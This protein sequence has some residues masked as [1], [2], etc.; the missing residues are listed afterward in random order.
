MKKWF[1]VGLLT[2][3][4]ACIAGLLCACNTGGIG[5]LG[6]EKLSAPSSIS[7]DGV[8]LTWSSVDGAQNY[9]VVIG[10][11]T[12]LTA[13][14][15]SISY[16]NPSGQSFTVT[17]TANAE[18]RESSDSVS[19]TFV[20]LAK[21]EEIDVAED[22]TLSW[23]VVDFAT[24]YTLKI[25]GVETP[26]TTVSYDGLEAGTH[27]VSVKPTAA[28]ANEGTS[29]YAQ[30]SAEK[31]I[32]ICGEVEEESIAYSAVTGRLTWDAV[33]GAS[34]YR[35]QISGVSEPV[36]EVVTST[37]Y[38]YDALNENFMA[39]VQAVGNHSS[40]F[41]AK[42]STSRSFVYLET[43]TG[44]RVEDGVLYWNEVSGAEGYR[45]MINDVLVQNTLTEC[46]YSDFAAGRSV[47]VNVMPVSGDAVYFSSWTSDFSFTILS[48]PVLQWQNYAL[49]GTANNNLYWD[50]IPNAQGYEVRLTKDG[51]V[52]D[53]ATL[54]QGV[55]QYGNA[56]LET[57]EYMVEVKALAD[58]TSSNICDSKYSAPIYIIRLPSPT[59]ADNNYITSDA[60]NVQNGFTVTFRGVTGATGYR[61]W[62]DNTEYA[63]TTSAQWHESAVIGSSVIE[64]QEINY[65][66][67]SIGQTIQ[68]VGGKRTVIL[69]SLSD[70]ALAFDITVL[71]A[72]TGV[73]ITGYEYT[74]QSVFGSFGYTVDIGGQP[75]VNDDL[76]YDLSSLTAGSHNVR[77]CAR[78]ND[79]D[80][81]SSNY[82]APIN[83]QRL[84]A[85]LDVRIETADAEEGM[86]SFTEVDYATGYTATFDGGDQAI[87]V[88]ELG[89]V[90]R[91]ISTS[92]TTV[93]LQATANYFNDLRTVYYMTSQPGETVNFIKLA[94]PTFGD[95]RFTGSQLVWNAPDNILTDEFTPTYQVY[96]AQDI[97][98]NGE[99]NGTVMS[100]DY[101]EGG[102]TYTFKVKAVGNVNRYGNTQYINS[103]LS[104]TISVYKLAAPQITR[105]ETGYSWNAVTNAISYAV[106][107]DGV[108]S[109]T[110]YH[111]SGNVYTF[112][113]N[114]TELKTYNVNVYAIGDNGATAIDSRPAELLQETKQLQTPDFE[115]SY[116]EE[117]VS[118]NGEIIV[119][120]TQE[121]PYARGYYYSV[122]GAAG[123]AA[124]TEYRYNANGAGSFAI[125][126]Y[127]LGGGFDEDGVYYLDSQSRGGNAAYTIYLLPAPNQN[128][129]NINADGY[130]TWANVSNANSY[131][132][133]LT[134]NG[135]EKEAITVTTA[136]FDINTIVSYRDVT[137]LTVSVRAKGNSN[138]VTSA[139]SSR[140]WAVIT[141]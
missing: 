134:I 7:Y 42:E 61:I 76:S 136:S 105:T 100:T 92:G 81:L 11:Q 59:F 101:L 44:L 95:T 77:V 50:S 15:N 19:H 34:A 43:A 139:Q 35:L 18:G 51:E 130:I 126:V 86:L 37:S 80:I 110:D 97:L 99:R 17:I 114:F 102:A 112:T 121:S 106:Y 127:A 67:Q 113:P 9:S 6:N 21:I 85:P 63:S 64:Q 137:S 132:L 125:V 88:N 55:V 104:E 48:S 73:D 32:T 122:G 40:S 141:H 31:R 41:D 58:N 94:T 13:P 65:K 20:P 45:L 74:W 140:E 115:F 117:Y 60:E 72:P 123:T 138:C 25:D 111:V 124:G 89:N 46:S 84:A 107:V 119:N 49:D 56:Y 91:R 12:S 3:M 103:D 68:S 116:S 23:D 22:G 5:E 131:E 79:R 30:Y 83:V 28:S 36:D 108:L 62:K 75:Y 1:M 98:Q 52:I 118:P 109:S 29:Y 66:I 93:F 47:T 87:P 71:A 39:S 129:I 4:I 10:E 53:S 2:V 70:N 14:N 135:E 16:S 57:G 33:E 82:T 90:N 78:G 26:L 24:G 27:T 69:D 133:I 128:S 54:A 38:E 8:Q 96:N 120:I